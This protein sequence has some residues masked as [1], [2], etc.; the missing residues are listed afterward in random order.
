MVHNGL[1]IVCHSAGL[2]SIHLLRAEPCSSHGQEGSGTCTDI[3]HHFAFKVGELQ[4]TEVSLVARPI[5]Q[6]NLVGFNVLIGFKVLTV[7]F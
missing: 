7:R 5:L 1:S 2:H 4:R 3:Q 6:H